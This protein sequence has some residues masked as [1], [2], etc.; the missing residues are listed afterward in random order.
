[1]L[2]MWLARKHTRAAFSDISHY[3]G[4]RSHS[5]VISAE[6][7]VACWMSAGASIQLGQEACPIAEAIQRVER[8]LRTGS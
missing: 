4:R 3:F 8:Q 6:K 1:M 2:A 5:T 7:K